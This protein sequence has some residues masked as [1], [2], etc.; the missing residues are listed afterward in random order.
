MPLRAEIT[1]GLM[2]DCLIVGGTSYE[3]VGNMAP[4]KG[5]AQCVHTLLYRFM[6]WTLPSGVSSQSRSSPVWW[7]GSE[8]WFWVS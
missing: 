1:K 3:E 4:C 7:D 6:N 8:K 5:C 2:S